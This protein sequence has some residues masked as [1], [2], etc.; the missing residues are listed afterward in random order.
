[1]IHW[2]GVIGLVSCAGVIAALIPMY[3]VHYRAHGRALTAVNAFHERGEPAPREVMARTYT[4]LSAVNLM[5]A[6]LM[7]ACF[8]AIVFAQLLRL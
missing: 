5:T 8:I 6:R 3:A 7:F 4:E 2:I 1:M